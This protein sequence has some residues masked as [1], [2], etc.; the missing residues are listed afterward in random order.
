MAVAADDRDSILGEGLTFDDVLLVPGHSLVHPREPSLASVLTT[1]IPISV[2]KYIF[3]LVRRHMSQIIT[4]VINGVSFRVKL[5][6]VKVL[7]LI[8]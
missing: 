1:G 7:S 3:F 2:N 4:T 8:T 6:R 5:R